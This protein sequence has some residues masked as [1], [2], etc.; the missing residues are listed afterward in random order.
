MYINEQISDIIIAYMKDEITLEQ[1]AILDEWI[2][3]SDENKKIFDKLTDKEFISKQ[4]NLFYSFEDKKAWNK[5][6]GDTQKVNQITI[7]RNKIW[8]KL[9]VAAIFIGLVCATYFIYSYYKTIHQPQTLVQRNDVNPP[10]LSKAFIKMDNGK[11]IML[12]SIK[13]NTV[14]KLNGAEVIKDK[15]GQIVY[16]GNSGKNSINTLFNQR[17][18]N[19]ITLVL[20]DGTKVWLNSESSISY[21]LKFDNGTRTVSITGEAYFEVAKSKTQKF[22]VTTENGMKTEVLGTHF[23]IKDYPDDCICNVTLLEG[24]IQVSNAQSKVLLKPEQQAIQKR[25]AYAFSI[26]RANIDNVMAWKSGIFYFEDADIYSIT[27]QLSRWYNIDV[28]IK[29]TFSTER[30]F[31]IISRNLSLMQVLQILKLA[32]INYELKEK[33]LFITK[34]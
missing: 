21:P 31:G 5:I 8:Q 34:S 1:K 13:N 25:N 16:T 28:Q 3:S 20:S 33:T 19:V 29:G 27:T 18:S 12:D 10:M 2:I 6:M 14:F 26:G 30:Y 32:D 7:F 17:G 24:S 22:I 23:N 15:T 9:A 11:V 4:L